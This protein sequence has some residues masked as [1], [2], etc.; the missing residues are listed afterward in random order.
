MATTSGSRCARRRA[1]RRPPN[2]GNGLTRQNPDD[3]TQT[4]RIFVVPASS[5]VGSDRNA[6]LDATIAGFLSFD[7]ATQTGPARTARPCSD[8]PSNNDVQLDSRSVPAIFPDGEVGLYVVSL[9]SDN[10][11]RAIVLSRRTR[12]PRDRAR[13]GS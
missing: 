3:L 7:Q 9:G 11:V 2:E 6:F 8:E 5:E 12:R 10:V 13:S 4:V 1:G